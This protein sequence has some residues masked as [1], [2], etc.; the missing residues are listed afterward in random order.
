MTYNTM[1]L[2]FY[3]DCTPQ[4]HVQGKSVLSSVQSPDAV[5]PIKDSTEQH[6]WDVEETNHWEEEHVSIIADALKM[7]KRWH[8]LLLQS[9]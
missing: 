8:G 4:D 9:V 3:N 1:V 6:S 7:V 2:S 5:S